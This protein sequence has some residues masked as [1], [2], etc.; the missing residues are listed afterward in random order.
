MLNNRRKLIWTY[1]R[2]CV[3]GVGSV[4]GPALLVL[5]SSSIGWS[6]NGWKVCIKV[7]YLHEVAREIRVLMSQVSCVLLFMVVVT[8]KG[9]SGKR[10]YIGFLSEPFGTFST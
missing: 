9:D 8:G 4:A 1:T 2:R 10:L 6:V 7:I 3:G 5:Y